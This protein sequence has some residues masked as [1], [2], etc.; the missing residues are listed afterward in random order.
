[1]IKLLL[2][3]ALFWPAVASA[4]PVP[5]DFFASGPTDQKRFAL[6]FDDG[7]GPYTERFLDLLDKYKVKATFFMSGDQV[8]RRK[9][10]AKKVADVGHEVANHTM[11]HVN[12]RLRLKKLK[13]EVKVKEELVQDILD[14][15]FLIDKTTGVQPKILRMPHGIDRPWINEAARETG[16]VLVNWTYGADW[17]KKPLE[18]LTRS[19]QKAVRPGAI[20]LFHD[21]GGR[22]EKSLAL[23]EAVL[24]EAKK[25]GFEVVTVGE[26]IGIR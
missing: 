8:R 13:D 26:L 11:F 6:S 12:Y 15:G 23:V 10:T 2:T 18:E 3:L 14:T 9:E 7:P 24:K 25:R 16:F 19:Y 21:G 4:A 17:T 5:G 1:M 20:L 22:R